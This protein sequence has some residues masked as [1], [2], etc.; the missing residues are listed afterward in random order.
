[1]S[2][3]GQPGPKPGAAVRNLPPPPVDF[4]EV[5]A[6]IAERSFGKATI[7]YVRRAIF[8]LWATGYGPIQISRLLGITLARVNRELKA[9]GDFWRE[10][11]GQAEVQHVG[12]LLARIDKAEREVWAAWE[13]SKLSVTRDLV[14]EKKGPPVT[15]TTDDGV[16]VQVDGAKVTM[17]ERVVTQRVGDARF[18]SQ[19]VALLALR[20]RVLLGPADGGGRG[21][22]RGGSDRLPGGAGRGPAIFP[23]ELFLGDTLDE[24]TPQLEAFLSDPAFEPNDGKRAPQ[25]PDITDPAFAPVVAPVA[26]VVEMKPRENGAANGAQPAVRNG[27]GREDDDGDDEGG[28]F[29]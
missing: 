15:R 29:F 6:L 16:Q 25:P 3:Q 27:A 8:D 13:R 23:D 17:S 18:M 28:D 5:R 7:L 11:A 2:T 12:E 26:V 14:R 19:I 10:Y 9:Y 1:M 21:G 24:T 4:D 22:Q 20:S